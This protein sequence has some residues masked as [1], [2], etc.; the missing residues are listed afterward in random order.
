MKKS[1]L[2]LI[3]VISFSAILFGQEVPPHR[4]CGTM[5][6][7][8]Y[9]KQTRKNYSEDVIRYNQMLDQY[10]NSPQF[11]AMKTTATIN[12]PV[13][14]HVVYRTAT[15][16][17]SDAQAISQFSV[18][19][20]DFNRL[21]ADSVNTPAA[22]K[23]VAGRMGV[24]F[25][26]A[27]RDPNGNPTT[28]V[29]HKSTTTTS[30]TT[31]DKVKSSSTGGDDPWDVTKYV[32]IWVCNIGGGILG[33][34]EFPTGTLS[35]TWGLVLN[36]TA[37][38]TMGTAASPYN[39]GRTGTH[40]FGHCFNL[41]HIWGDNGQCGASDGCIDT[42]PQK[43][44][45]ASPAGCNYGAPTY[46][47]QPNTCTRP[48]G[49]AG[50]N[51]TN[52]NGDM[53]MNY[54]DYTN[55]A[56]MNMFTKNQCTKMMAVLTTSPWNVLASSNGCTPVNALDASIA[57]IMNP[58]AGTS[59]CNNNVT[60]KV[61]L[62]NS[63]STT[64]TSAKVLYK[65][66]ASA[67]QTLN[68]SGT[69]AT[70]ASTVLT[71]NT[72]SGL[73][74]AAHTF[75][76]WS[77]A[78]NAGTDQYTAND[79][80]SS[81]FTVIAA[82]AS[83]ALPFTENFESGAT[84][85]TGWAIQKANTIDAAVSWSVI[86]N[87]TGLTAGST[88]V[89]R[90]DNYSSA[91]DIHG[92]ID[93][94][95]SPALTF[96]A[97]NSS[98]NLT[99]DVSHR[100]YATTS[101]IDTLN[102]YISTDCGGSWTKL[103]TKGGAQL[104]TAVGT[105]T[106]AFTPTA[107][108]QWR[109]E[110]V[111][112]S[113]YAGVSSVY[114]KFESMS[115]YGNDVYLDNIN[116][117]YT[118]AVTPPVANFST[119]VTS[120][121]TASSV[122]LTD[123]STNTPTSWSWSV[124]PSAGVAVSSATVQN[125]SVTFA[126]AGTY[127]ITLTATNG[128]G[129]NA[130]TKTI[131]VVATPTANA[132]SA[133]VLTCTNTTASLIGSGGSAYSWTGTGITGGATTATAT[134]NAAGTYSLVVS[135]G[136]CSSPIATVAVTQNTVTPS[137]V[138]A[139]SGTLTC[140]TVTVN[141]SAT[142]T[143]T[144]VSYAWTG[145]G[146]TAGA[147]TGTITANQAGTFNYTVTNT[148]NGCKAT[149]ALVITQNTVAPG[150]T[151][152][153][154]G[155]LTCSATTVNA[156]ATTLTTPVSYAWTGPGIA[157]GASTGT[158]TANQPGTYNYTVTSTVNG[159][160]TT[161]LRTVAQN[162]VV[163]TLTV[164][165]SQTISCAAPT[166][167]LT[168]SATPSTCTPVW[169]GG[170]TSGATSYTATA[171]SPN[172]YTLT[173]TN[174]ANGCT[175]SATTLVSSSAGVPSVIASVTNTL[176]CTNTTAQVVATTTM[177]GVSYSWSGPSIT[178]GA[179]TAS[180]TVNGAGT[181]TVVVT[182]TTSACSSTV[183]IAATQNTT[184][185]AI[186]GS[187]S[188][189]LTCTSTTVN[190]SVSTA[191]TPVSYVWTGTGIT[192]GASTATVTV[193]QPGTY[194][195][196][197]TNTSNGCKTTG[198]KVVIQNTVTPSVVGTTSGTLTCLALTVNASATTTST[199]VSYNWSGTGITAGA[200][201]GTI[202]VNQPGT[203]NYTVTNTTNGCKATGSQVVTQNATAPSASSS[204]SGVL[205]C[206]NSTANVMVST[207][208]SPVSY[209]WSGTGI[210]S[211]ASTATAMV[212]QGGT[213][214]YTV[215]NTS[216]GCTTTGSQV[217][218]SNTVAPSVS[219]S[220]TTICAGGTAT[221]TASGS[222]ATYS[223]NTGVTGAVLTVSPASNAS[224]TVI[225]TGSNGC[226]A[227]ATVDVVVGSA[228]S[229]SVNSAAICTGQTATLTASGVTTYTWNTSS[230]AASIIVNPTGTTVYTVSG[231]LSGCS[232]TAVG[233]ATVTVNTPPTVSLGTITTPLCVD[234]GTIAL[235]GT[236][237]GGTFTGAGVTGSTFDPAAAG[238]GTATVVYN[239]TDVNSCSGSANQS[240]VVSLCTGIT[241]LNNTS[242]V[243]YPNPTRDAVNIKLDASMI[244]NAK[245]ELYDAIGKLVIS[246]EVGATITTL[247]LNHLARGMYTIRVVSG[248]DQSLIK[249][250]KE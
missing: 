198:S 76:V 180:A 215:T 121:C 135:N 238:A 8:E 107:N 182:N 163:P 110:T 184:A 2:T 74:T 221:L 35:S 237:M 159:C 230:N 219:V 143:L 103:Y 201:T 136:S 77:A 226:T 166:V 249:V 98:L 127:S 118:T 169:I 31:D 20:N 218:T 13:V 245:I 188:G 56:V 64:L 210:V 124:T 50:A 69:L 49:V 59:T 66:D 119:S 173:V 146:I 203:F 5:D 231:N 32:N 208:A 170:V 62:L 25:C 140:A 41:N 45:T 142:T 113:S 224:Y 161:G 47:W 36:Y 134:V 117:S 78:P 172:T 139:T 1:L 33:Y 19:N 223:W 151:G 55:D 129:S 177:T 195:Y 171:S 79:N 206:T 87:T 197:V 63:G 217:V 126:N 209:N 178:A 10:M 141:A 175:K 241:E 132:G 190:A 42:P 154:S 248:N 38:G 12:V 192:A 149:G 65:M 233:T 204:V 75:S 15:E 158:I 92:Q 28:G 123:M 84:P 17:I 144:P 193:N 6:H 125:P 120:A 39:K 91:T 202:T 156:D 81:T 247:S 168:G 236:P 145:T 148:S 34:G 131:T 96:T 128:G 102:V 82:P 101:Y 133:A 51:V 181:Y 189:T 57:S 211:G 94:L 112:L 213:Y 24:N 53:F 61:T 105:Q 44:G 185:P 46:P 7:H 95:R 16:N 111:S 22:F 165:A 88:K 164:S 187:T 115:G 90:M 220:S 194:N 122:Q 11:K 93:A 153:V 199:P 227:T 86:A 83:Q 239:Y 191:A 196:T 147:A 29:V 152:T 157:S 250:V 71:L 244:N 186:S 100:P 200:T 89:A 222:V 214:N 176:T 205:D 97:A 116:V 212:S 234:N 18:L 48:D 21:N 160:S 225:A 216:N 99:F 207:A 108:A 4:T 228:P 246:E 155:T 23:S 162:T 43:G 232:A 72:F 109:K 60:P 40:E 106:T 52:T 114:L 179:T 3:A 26:L 27:Q 104:S 138:G 150:V 183:T 14:I 37:T 9:L 243:V 85:P 68:W 54:M 174:P 240:V 58:F 229:I 80:K 235:T 242:V 167:T 137:V 67:T 73:T 130:T 30:F 70:G